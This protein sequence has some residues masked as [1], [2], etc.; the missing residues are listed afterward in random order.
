[1]YCLTERTCRRWKEGCGWRDDLSEGRGATEV[2]DMMFDDDWKNS[3]PFVGDRIEGGDIV[4][5]IG[6]I[7]GR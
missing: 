4:E 6:A 1:V 7:E 3:G 2:S 5:A